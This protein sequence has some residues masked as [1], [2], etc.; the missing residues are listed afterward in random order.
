MKILHIAVHLGGGAGKA[1]AGIALECKSEAEQKIIILEKPNDMTYYNKLIENKIDILIATSIEEVQECI[2]ENDIVILN[3][4]GHPLM[5]KLL[6]DLPSKTTRLII[7][8]HINGCTYPY[9]SFEFLN[10]FI[11]TL[12]TSKYS[13][14]N[15]IWTQEE[16][17]SIKERSKVIYGMGDFSPRKLR[18]KD[19]YDIGEKLKIGYVGTLN[20]AKLSRN[21]LSYYQQLIKQIPNIQFIMLGRVDEQILYDIE[22]RKLENYFVF[23]GFVDKPEMY[24]RE[25][26]LFVYLLE[27]GN[28]GTTENVLLEAM[29][30]GLPIIV[31][32]NLLERNIIVNGDNGFLINNEEEFVSTVKRLHTNEELRR[33][34]GKKARQYVISHYDGKKNAQLLM[35]ICK[36]VMNETKQ[37]YNFRNVL[38]STGFEAFCKLAR[39][40][41]KV[42]E[43]YIRKPSLENGNKI[44]E[45]DQIFKVR[46]KGSIY[47]YAEIFSQEWQFKKIVEYWEAKK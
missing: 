32:N 47:Q 4:W 3:W 18:N 30:Y 34:I 42:F 35:T 15:T 1:I 25:F 29:A 27:D 37:A 19:S 40:T 5:V 43:D 41:G 8:N 20:Y 12:F 10:E 36:K 13:Y 22:E 9:L 21:F 17:K 31:F 38:G 23:P 26:D 46:S 7:W 28:Y 39:K 2:E 33:N 6:I 11:F 24:Y 16:Y 14:Q 45:V 44:E